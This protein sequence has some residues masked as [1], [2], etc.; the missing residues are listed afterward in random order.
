MRNCGNARR[1]GPARARIV[2]LSVLAA[3]LLVAGY[4]A[5]LFS[6]PNG[7]AA[8]AATT[9]TEP[10]P[11][12]DP[13]PDPAPAPPPPKPAPKPAPTPAPRPAPKPAPRPAPKPAPTPASRP[14]TAYH[15]P[16]TRTAAAPQRTYSQPVV[17]RAKPKVVHHRKPSRRKIVKRAAVKRAVVK[18]PPKA[19][20]KSANVV[21]VADVPAAAVTTDNGDAAR[22]ALLIGGLGVGAL[23][24]LL[25]FAVPATAA[26]F[27][28]PGRSVIDH[29]TDLMLTGVATL[30]LTAMLFLVTK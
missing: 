24:F 10:V 28:A 11:E 25:V 18:L 3:C 29:R 9:E 8:V 30:L 4:A 22:Q 23:L 19:E 20:V 16:S 26:R 13:A 15:A 12:P 7:V 17:P 21:R 27:T 14:A 5:T 6:A 2:F 1:L